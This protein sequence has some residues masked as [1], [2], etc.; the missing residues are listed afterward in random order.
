MYVLI[1]GVNHFISRNEVIYVRI[2][3]RRKLPATIFLRMLGY[4]SD[5]AI[6]K[7]LSDDKK[8]IAKTIEKDPTKTY[9]EAILEIYKKVRPGEP[10]V[11]ENARE[12]INGMF[13]NNRMYNL[14]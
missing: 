6:M 8:F 14:W 3:R 5:E 12:R 13:F 11:V 1:A 10:L 7:L 2:D 4:A 9:E